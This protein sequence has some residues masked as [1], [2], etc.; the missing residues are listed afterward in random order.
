MT[1]PPFPRRGSRSWRVL[2]AVIAACACGCSAATT[3]G[4]FPAESRSRPTSGHVFIMPPVIGGSPGI[5]NVGR[6]FSD[7][8]R[9]VAARLLAIV[10]ERDPEAQLADATGQTPYL[11]MKAYIDAV[12]PA[13]TTAVELN[14]AG[15]ARQHGGT[16]LLVPTILEWREMRTDDP[17]G[18]LTLPHEG[19]AIAFRLV[20]LDAPAVEGDVTF[21]NHARVTVNRPA[22]SL[23]NDDFRRAVL[24]LVGGRA[25]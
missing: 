18:A 20:R 2:V 9:V 21:R 15:F 3:T 8:E 6:N 19:V 24:R 10:Q 17:I 23:L 14:A 12:A 22:K 11:P 5:G 7:I 25:G 1:M 4:R 16:Y 13:R